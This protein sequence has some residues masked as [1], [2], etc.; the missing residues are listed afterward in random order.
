MSIEIFKNFKKRLIFNEFII[1]IKSISKKIIIFHYFFTPAL[2]I[3]IILFYKKKFKVL[4]Y[5]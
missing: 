2:I 4:V 1:K 5:F 3:D